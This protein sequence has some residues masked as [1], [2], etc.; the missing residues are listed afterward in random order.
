MPLTLKGAVERELKWI[1]ENG[2]ASVIGEYKVKDSYHVFV[3]LQVPRNP[4]IKQ[5]QEHGFVAANEYVLNDPKDGFTRGFAVYTKAS[6]RFV[7]GVKVNLGHFVYVEVFARKR[8][9]D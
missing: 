9:R 6:G 8:K 3:T 2:G 4:I 7:V 1:M 5:L